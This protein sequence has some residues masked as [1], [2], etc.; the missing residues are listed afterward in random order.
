MPPGARN[1]RL[2]AHHPR[3]SGNTGAVPELPDVEGHARFWRKHA[4]GHTVRRVRVTDDDVLRNTTRQGLGRALAGRRLADP[5]R[6]GKWLLAPTDGRATLLVH[7]GM[8]GLLVSSADEDRFHPHDRVVIWL[9]EGWVAYRSQRK[10]GGLWLVRSDRER[11]EITGRLGPDAAEVDRDRLETL[12]RGRRGGL[13]AALMNQEVMAG[14]GNEL[15]DEVLWRA[16]IHPRRSVGDLDGDDITRLAHALDQAV[17]DSVP[18]G[19][20]PDDDGW[21]NAVRGE[22]DPVC[23]RCGAAV[24]HGTVA[25]RTAYWCSEEQPAP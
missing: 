13:K 19:R 1:D 14:V 5:V 21:L 8:T 12:L 9:S 11:E 25:G 22:P 6:W 3:H 23:P 4:A 17:Q 18:A 16:G 20:I 24:S 7:F 2:N 10:L 15:S